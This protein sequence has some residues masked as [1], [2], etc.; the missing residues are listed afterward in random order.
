[1]GSRA[2]D[3]SQLCDVCTCADCEAEAS[4]AASPRFGQGP[5]SIGGTIV[6]F[7]AEVVGK[8][9]GDDHEQAS[10]RT[11]LILQHSCAM[12]DRSAQSRVGARS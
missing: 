10:C 5:P 12:A 11:R 7:V 6:T 8:A 2:E 3:A 4:G 1:M 9:V